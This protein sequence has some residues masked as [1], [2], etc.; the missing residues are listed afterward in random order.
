MG[1]IRL[2]HDLAFAPQPAYCRLRHD[3]AFWL[4]RFGVQQ[5]R[6]KCHRSR[7]RAGER[8]MGGLAGLE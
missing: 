1:P 6:H 5:C 3:L 8:W 7:H 4:A 2:P